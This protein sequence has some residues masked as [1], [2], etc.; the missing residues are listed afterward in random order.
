MTAPVEVIANFERNRN[1][2]RDLVNFDSVLTEL[3]VESFRGL[4]QKWRTHLEQDHGMSGTVLDTHGLSGG[5]QLK[6]FSTIREN[7]SLKPG[8]RAIHNLALV[9]LVSFFSSACRSMF[10]AVATESFRSGTSALRALPLKLTI[11]DLMQE[12]DLGSVV[13]EALEVS[14]GFSFQDMKSV[15]RAF[16]L[17]LGREFP[18]DRHVN[19]VVL[20]QAC[21]HAIVHADGLVDDKLVHQLRDA[22]PRTLKPELVLGTSIQFSPEEIEQAGSSMLEYLTFVV[23]DVTVLANGESG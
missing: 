7:E 15:G 14:E 5:R 10:K 19:D 20:A 6:M 8:F 13:A 16:K 9:A 11:G 23:T 22:N 1:S 3:V 12:S 17:V 18:R 2:V 21:R 4:N